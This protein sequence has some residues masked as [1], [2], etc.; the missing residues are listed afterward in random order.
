M[1]DKRHTGEQKAANHGRAETLSRIDGSRQ[2][3]KEAVSFFRWLEH[4]LKRATLF[5]AVCVMAASLIGWI[6][7]RFVSPGEVSAELKQ[8]TVEGFTRQDSLRTALAA[9]IH[10]IDSVQTSAIKELQS[11]A[12]ESRASDRFQTYALCIIARRVDPTITPPECGN[13]ILQYRR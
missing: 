6:G 5:G 7:G 11:Q 3:D 10:A 4:S 13:V 2:A 8:A 9:E 1:T 12:V